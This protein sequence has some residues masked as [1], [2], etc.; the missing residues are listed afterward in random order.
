MYYVELL[1]VF[2]AL[3]IV[4]LIL[5]AMPAIAFVVRA[6]AGPH[7][8][9]AVEGMQFSATA[10][11]SSKQLADGTRLTI[12]RDD[13]EHTVFI[14]RS[15]P[16][17]VDIT[18]Y[19]G[20]NLNPSVL[21]AL[22]GRQQ[23]RKGATHH[24]HGGM[25]FTEG[26]L[27]NGVTFTHYVNSRY[28]PIDIF[29][30]IAGMIGALFATI[31]G[32]SL[33]KENDGHLELAW[34]K[35]ASR[36]AF[37]FAMFGIDAAAILLVT[38]LTVLVGLTI[39]AIY[40]GFPVPTSTS[41]TP[42]NVLMAILFPIAWYALGQALSAS[43]RR[44]GLIL[45][46]LWIAAL[47]AI[48]LLAVDNQLLRVTLRVLNTINPLAYYSSRN[49]HPATFNN[50]SLNLLPAT[51]LFDILGLSAIIIVAIVASLFQWRRLEA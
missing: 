46:V 32:G 13:A 9:A 44:A 26:T 14:E 25:L 2:R 35:P 12:V 47:G 51:Q 40:T 41:D 15:S 42:G 17:V 19:E 18:V 29:L 24:E 5:L 43:L 21:P 16:G 30:V 37:A 3:R 20:K 39:T 45:G 8:S 48:G 36:S 27:P 33:S 31:I 34:T 11:R 38:A 4:V 10:R 23:L 1:R 22:T 28:V 6:E 7:W 49:G 50:A